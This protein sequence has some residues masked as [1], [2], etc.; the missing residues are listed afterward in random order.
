MRLPVR[1]ATANATF[2]QS[3]AMGSEPAPY[4]LWRASYY[5][6]WPK[7]RISAS[8]SASIY[9]VLARQRGA[10][11]TISDPRSPAKAV[12]AARFW[13]ASR[14]PIVEF[15]LNRPRYEPVKVRWPF[16]G[17]RRAFLLRHGLAIPLESEVSFGA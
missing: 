7:S 17:A 5:A 9:S 14:E 10:Q 2:A 3:F 4:S 1:H 8:A 11:D 15:G 13:V 6:L 16:R 12:A